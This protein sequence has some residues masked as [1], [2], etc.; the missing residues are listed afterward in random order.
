MADVLIFNT[1]DGGDIAIEQGSPVLT[2]GL[3]SMAYLCLF[4]GNG[5]DNGAPDNPLSWWGNIGESVRYRSQTQFLLKSV[6]ATPFNLRRIESAALSDLA[7]F[8][9][10]NIVS[11]LEV[12]ASIPAV[13]TVVI[14]VSLNADGRLE[15]FSFTEAW[16]NES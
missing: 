2:G 11:D 10:E 4:G 15:T 13:N 6:A 1:L 16:P 3:E 12:S 14:D 5:D 9:N 8:Q 7:I